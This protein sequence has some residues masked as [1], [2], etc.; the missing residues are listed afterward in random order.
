M[1]LTHTGGVKAAATDAATGL[2]ANGVADNDVWLDIMTS[3]DVVLC[4][5][6]FSGTGDGFG[7]ANG[8][9]GVA[10]AVSIDNGT[11]IATGTAAKFKIYNDTNAHTCSGSVGTSGADIILNNVSLVSGQIVQITSMTYAALP[12]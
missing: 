11:C 7:A 9:T 10:T 8:T 6:S 3:A 5:L 2:F 12:A 1:S 4:T